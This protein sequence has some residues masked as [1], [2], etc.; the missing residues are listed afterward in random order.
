M[1]GGTRLGRGLGWRAGVEIQ[2]RWR[3]DPRRETHSK[4]GKAALAAL[5]GEEIVERVG[6]GWVGWVG[7]DGVQRR[8]QRC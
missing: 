6:R 3:L 7:G 8:R 1:V 5:R 2:W 4:V